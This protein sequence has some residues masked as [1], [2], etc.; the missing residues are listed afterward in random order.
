MVTKT[1]ERQRLRE[2][3]G[4][5]EFLNKIDAMGELQVVEGA[6]W[7]LE[8]GT[9]VELNA[10]KKNAK[11]LL[12]DQIKGYPPGFRVL[13]TSMT[14]A[15]RLALVL[16][17]PTNL[18]DGE[19]VDALK[20]KPK[21]W[22]QHALEF[23]PEEVST[24]PW[25]EN[26]LHGD[27]INMFLFPTPFWHELD[28]GR[29]LGTG[30]N[31]ITR[32]AETGVIN[33]GTYRVQ[34]HDE[35]TVGLFISPGKHGRL[36]MENWHNRGEAM[37]VA[38]SFGHDPLLFCLGATEIPLST[39]EYYVAGAIRGEALP[40]V[41]GPVTGL[42]IPADAEIVIEG[43][44]PPDEARTEGPFGEWTG[45]YGSGERPEPVIK[46]KALYY[47]NNPIIL[48]S[49][50]GRPPCDFSYFRSA[51]RSSLI[52]EAVERAGVPD[53][54][55]VWAHPA[56]GARLFVVISIKQRY[57]GHARQAAFVASQ[58]R[59]GAYLGRYVVVVDEDIDPTNLEDVLWA[60]CTRS[61]PVN[62][63]DFIRRSYSG[64]LDPMI[65][66]GTPGKFNSRAIIDACRPWEWMSEFPAVSESSPELVAKVRE[67]WKGTLDL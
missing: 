21:Q 43:F 16:G 7:H 57:A 66:P 13:A 48:G 18:S 11:A 41:K 14:N 65:R 63:I 47:R 62:D 52:K 26:V 67:K 35:K 33:A 58:C 61:D 44:V 20:G 24:A 5:R 55:G 54:Q 1:A 45:Y 32:D 46:V 50:P 22:E 38:V 23:P 59:E 6:D 56:G 17:L 34:V 9:L 60:I 37:P 28:G 2:Y 36:Q 25:M 12:F 3:D 29:Y 30:H 15:A 53:V 8:I 19:L 31:V 40:V 64:V 4:L 42:P 49:P 39:P 51:L 10:R 27:A